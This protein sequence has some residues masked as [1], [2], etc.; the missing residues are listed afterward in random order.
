M[1]ESLVL[2][3]NI[4]RKEGREDGMEGLREGVRE[5]GRHLEKFEI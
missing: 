5:G 3:P 1:S 2:I 4:G